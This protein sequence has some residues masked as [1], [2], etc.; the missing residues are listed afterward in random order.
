MTRTERIEAYFEALTA[1]DISAILALFTPEAE[2]H[3]PFLGVLNVSDFYAR[4]DSAS[5]NSELTVLDV[6]MGRDSGAARFRYD[7]TLKSGDNIVFEG[8]D[9]FTFGPDDRFTAMR[10]YYDTHPVREDVGDKY[11]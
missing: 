8:V 11:A 9:H 10:I 2:I 7:W 5:A 4:L 1:G 3:S 6:L